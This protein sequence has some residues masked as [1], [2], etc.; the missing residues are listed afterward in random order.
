MKKRLIVFLAA[1][2]VLMLFSSSYHAFASSGLDL[3]APVVILMEKTTGRVLY[4]R[5]EHEPVYPASLTKMLT[6]LV[7]VEHLDMDEILVVG[8]EI[9]NM[10]DGYVTNLHFE[11]ETITVRMLLRAL[12]MRSGNETGRVLALNVMRRYWH[13]RNITYAE[14]KPAFSQLMNNM[15]ASL[16]ATNTNFDNPYG[17]HGDSHVSTAYDLALIARAYMEHPDLAEIASIL[18]FVGD[19]LE[20]SF[21]PEGQTQQYEWISTNLM[22]PG[23]QLGHPYVTGLKT[24][25]TTPAGHCFAGAAYYNGLGLITV[26]LGGTEMGRWQDTRRLIDYGFM[27]YAFRIVANPGDIVGRAEIENSRLGDADEIDLVLSEGHEA[28]LSNA[29][30]ASVRSLL[31]I[32]PGYLAESMDIQNESERDNE[33]ESEFSSGRENDMRRLVAPIQE[34][35]PVGTMVFMAGD[36]ELFLAPVLAAQS[37]NERTFGSDMGFYWSRF[38][39]SVFTFRALPY[40]FGFVGT[41]IGVGGFLWG[42]MI[43]RR[44]RGLDRRRSGRGRPKTN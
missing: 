38:A 1:T 10:P 22:L 30:Y 41:L 18:F 44:A 16:G 9:R 19:S 43:S 5:N 31:H 40:W 27:N 15:A 24:G 7:V 21:H 34:G 37:V 3:E 13:M 2:M 29:E 33:D 4:G 35:S 8:T 6:A 17:L 36:A 11:G 39:G 28:L 23:S 42:L 32:D 25:F 14:A 20:G 26:T 12:M